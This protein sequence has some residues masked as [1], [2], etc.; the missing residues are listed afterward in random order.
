MEFE[1]N[2]D[3]GNLECIEQ[4]KNFFCVF[5]RNSEGVILTSVDG[6]TLWANAALGEIIGK[7]R[8]EIS[9]EDV[10]LYYEKENY[11]NCFETIMINTL[12]DGEWAGD[13]YLVDKQGHIKNI[14][15]NMF[16]MRKSDNSIDKIAG[17]FK[18]I[19]DE[20]SKDSTIYKLAYID[21]LTNLYNKEYFTLELE[22][23]ILEASKNLNKLAVIY[24]DLNCFKTINDSQGRYVGDEVLKYFTQLLLQSAGENAIVARVGGDEFA[25]MIPR[26]S[27]ADDIYV[28]SDRLIKELNMPVIINEKEIFIT[29]SAG[30]CIYPDDTKSGEELLHYADIAMYNAKDEKDKNVVRFTNVMKNNLDEY[31]NISN[32]LRRAIEKNEL[33]LNYQPIVDINTE[34][35]VGAEVLLRWNNKTLGSIPPDKF[36]PIAETCGQI[37]E[38]GEWVLREACK[39]S[40]EWYNKGY[41][42]IPLAVNVSIKQL[43]HNDFIHKLKAIIEDTGINTDY[44]EI[45]ITESISTENYDEILLV[46][47][48][49]KNF[50]IKI[51]IDDFGTGYSSLARLKAMAIHKLK[52]DR[53]FINDLNEVD[54]TELVSSIIALG[55]ALDLKLVAEGIENVR[56]LDFLKDKSCQYGQG[57]LFSKPVTKDLFED[58]LVLRS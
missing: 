2:N 36:I 58:C 16:L 28:V 25:V 17:I 47:E 54:K 30:I 5:E 3:I 37:L 52:I 50:G 9:S 29:F 13:V 22:N 1:S 27:N 53:A 39:Q 20:K 19:T 4:L 56:Q 8:H 10:I 34:K 57:F 14:F 26:I 43:E 55:K 48:Q 42:R 46:L 51:S 44:L 15:L 45:E 49:I 38:I 24:F 21:S 23:K 7:S 41:E 18:N 12:K 6:K 11:T 33:S 32:H 35:M 31:F 40:V